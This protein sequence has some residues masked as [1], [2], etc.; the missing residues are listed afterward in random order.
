MAKKKKK[1]EEDITCIF[2]ADLIP[3]EAPIRQPNAEARLGMSQA[4]FFKL[5]LIFSDVMSSFQ[6]D[7]RIVLPRNFLSKIYNNIY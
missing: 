7:R 3:S 5:K 1:T 6:V 4:G 2:T